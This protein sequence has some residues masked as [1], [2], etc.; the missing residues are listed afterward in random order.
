MLCKRDQWAQIWGVIR[1]HHFSCSYDLNSCWDLYLLWFLKALY[2]QFTRPKKEN[3]NAF[4]ACGHL[5]GRAPVLSVHLYSSW[6]WMR[7]PTWLFS[8][9]VFFIEYGLSLIYRHISVAYLN[10]HLIEVY[11]SRWEMWPFDR[12]G[13]FFYSLP[14]TLILAVSFC[15]STWIINPCFYSRI[16]VHPSKNC[17]TIFV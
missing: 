6:V 8:T 10:S 9:R 7:L 12:T 17:N 5:S 4:A 16:I 2:D 15:I 1:L 13:I 14:I 3:R 11:L